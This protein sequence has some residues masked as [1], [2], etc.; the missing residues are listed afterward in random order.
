MDFIRRWIPE[1]KDVP[2]EFIHEPWNFEKKTNYP[3]PIVNEKEARK[4]QLSCCMILKSP[5][6]TKKNITI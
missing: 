6:Q 1:L 2:T 4:K 3:Y 5:L